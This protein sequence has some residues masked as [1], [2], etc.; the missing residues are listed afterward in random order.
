M[1]LLENKKARSEYEIEK[2][3]TAGVVLTGGEVKSLRNSQ[4]SL[5]GSYVKILSGEAFLI[6]AQISPYKFADNSEYDPKRTRKLLLKKSEIEQL[7]VE[8]EQRKRTLVP[9]AFVI[10]GRNIK[11]SVGVGRGLKKFEKRE[12]IKKRDQERD[13][14]RAMK[15]G[16]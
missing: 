14:R 10:E 8:L 11:L 9:L 1:K 3:Y 6:G 12:K 16:K 2:T 13:M 7:M 4:G 15:W 5:N